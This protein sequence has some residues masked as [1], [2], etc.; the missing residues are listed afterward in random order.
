MMDFLKASDRHDTIASIARY[1][2]KTG[3]ISEEVFK[4]KLAAMGFEPDMIRREVEEHQ[5]F[6]P[7][8]KAIAK[9][10]AAAATLDA[11]VT[12]YKHRFPRSE[13]SVP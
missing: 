8:G 4:V 6:Q 9:V 1:Q 10:A 7:I 2:F 11:E 5:P 12:D 3:V 13:R